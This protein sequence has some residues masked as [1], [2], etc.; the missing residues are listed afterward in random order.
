MSVLVIRAHERI[1]VCR[2]VFLRRN[3]TCAG[4]G[5][6]IQLSL[7]GCRV[8]SLEQAEFREGN[9]V[10][11]WIEGHGRIGGEVRWA[12]DHGAGLLFAQ[13]LDQ[14]VLLNLLE[15]LQSETEV[16]AQAARAYGT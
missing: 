12:G 4:V 16:E 5:L 14:G 11:F 1:D 3:R 2:K 9:L 6:L 7:G 8:R 10:S 13:P 15:V